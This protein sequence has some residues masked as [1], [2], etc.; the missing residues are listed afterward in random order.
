MCA[1]AR[2]SHHLTGAPHVVLVG[3]VRRV[4]LVLGQPIP[5]LPQCA[6]DEPLRVPA[7]VSTAN[8][9]STELGLARDGPAAS[10]AT[11]RILQLVCHLGRLT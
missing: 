4:A 11:N 5:R 3:E 6:L 1:Y 8:N 2:L 10:P 7:A 9:S